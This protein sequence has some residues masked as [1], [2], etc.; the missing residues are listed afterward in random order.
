MGIT[1]PQHLT[2]IHS[3][4]ATQYQKEYTRMDHGIQSQQDLSLAGLL[5]FEENK[6]GWT[7]EEGGL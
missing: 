2:H 1:K 3:I 5:R 6:T 7:N 4:L